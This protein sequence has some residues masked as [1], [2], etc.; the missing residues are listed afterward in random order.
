MSN[1]PQALS[2]QNSMSLDDI[3]QDEFYGTPK[4]TPVRSR[5]VTGRT[6]DRAMM[7]KAVSIES[8]QSETRQQS[9]SPSKARYQHPDDIR[10]ISERYLSSQRRQPDCGNGRSYNGSSNGDSRLTGKQR[11]VE[12]DDTDRTSPDERAAVKTPEPT[13]LNEPRYEPRYEPPETPKRSPKLSQSPV[14]SDS[15]P[16]LKLA[17]PRSARSARE[18]KISFKDEK[19]REREREA[20]ESRKIESDFSDEEEEQDEVLS[21]DLESKTFSQEISE[22]EAVVSC[23]DLVPVLPPISKSLVVSSTALVPVESVEIKPLAMSKYPASWSSS[24]APASRLAVTTA[25]QN[26]HSQYS[27]RDIIIEISS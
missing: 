19:E 17:V 9:V 27:G 21:L 24:L 1:C 16:L 23:T 5:P 14:K 2:R 6:R 15:N 26:S 11:E 25:G 18:R 10:K 22:S 20:Q 12:S 13:F 7:S 4:P 8:L 3:S